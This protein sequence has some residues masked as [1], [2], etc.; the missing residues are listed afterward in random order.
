MGEI[1]LN[2][3]WEVGNT[4]VTLSDRLIC[5][6]VNNEVKRSCWINGIK[7]I[8]LNKGDGASEFTR[9]IPGHREAG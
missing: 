1:N 9:P 7:Q 3:N 5:S 6:C 2:Y 4:R 8:F